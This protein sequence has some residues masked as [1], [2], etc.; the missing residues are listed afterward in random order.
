MLGLEDLLFSHWEVSVFSLRCYV[1]NCHSDLYFST[2]L[3]LNVEM[4]VHS[5]F[6]L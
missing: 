2:L 5:D 1:L 4:I 3:S 6:C